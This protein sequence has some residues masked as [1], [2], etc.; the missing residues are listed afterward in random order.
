MKDKGSLSCSQ[1]PATDLRPVIDYK[2]VPNVSSK[3]ETRRPGD[4]RIILKWILKAWCEE[5]E[6]IK[7]A[8]DGAQRL[9]FVNNIT[10]FRV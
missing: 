1:K 10:R 7:V 8:Q 2:C 5:V 4:G 3:P 6:W 9:A